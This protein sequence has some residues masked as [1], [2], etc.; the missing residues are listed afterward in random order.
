MNRMKRIYCKP[1]SSAVGLT[2]PGTFED[3]SRASSGVSPELFLLS[4]SSEPRITSD[5]NPLQ[6]QFVPSKDWKYRLQL[7]GRTNGV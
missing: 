2:L 6:L 3:D 7:L 4:I 1:L 5:S